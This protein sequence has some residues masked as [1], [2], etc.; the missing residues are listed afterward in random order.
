MNRDKQVHVNRGTEIKSWPFRSPGPTGLCINC[1][2][3]S[4]V[5]HFKLYSGKGVFLQKVISERLK[6]WHLQAAREGRHPQ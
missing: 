1:L 2:K 6:W 5:L 3:G 4:K